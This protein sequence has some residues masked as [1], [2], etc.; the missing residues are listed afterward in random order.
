VISRTSTANY[1]S[2]P[3]NLPEI[4]R[5][6]HVG[7]ILEGSVQKFHDRVHINVQLIQAQTDTHLWAQSYDRQLIDMFGVEAE[8][9]RNIAESLRTTLSPEEKERLDARPTTNADA[10]VLYL[11]ARQYQTRPDTLLQDAQNAAQLYERAITLDPAFALAHAQLSAS[12]SAIY[13]WFQPTE[14]QK[15]KAHREAEKALQLQPN[16]G[17]AHLARGLYLY[18]C[19]GDYERGLEELRVAGE[20][21]PN[22]ADVGLYMAAIQRR[23]GHLA[24][25]IEQYKKAEAIDPRNPLV[26]EDAAQT[27]FLLRDWHSVIQILD[28]VLVL[29]PDSVTVKI[30]RA[31]TEFLG[32]GSTGPIKATLS[33]MP[34]GIDPDGTVTF[35]RWDVS[36]ID[37]DANAASQ[38]L[39]DS[40]LE[41]ITTADGTPVPKSYLQGCADLVR[42]DTARAQAEFESARP[43]IERT[44]QNSPS[45]AAR[46]AHLG[47]LMHSWDAGKRLCAKAIARSR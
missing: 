13:H 9:A 37:R 14:A 36:L 22:N 3:G 1:K 24:E 8:V 20:A 2:K 41:T 30:Q 43:M 32:K 39:A 5:E 18:Y 47:L 21:L 42:G 33:D 19:E 6:L 45:D 10:Y 23:Q 16:L 15:E 29:S 40:P 38:A 12:T 31:Y 17:E 4:A 7:N 11:R 35:A 26:L 34:I 27:Y 28:R 46:H 25:A 44:V